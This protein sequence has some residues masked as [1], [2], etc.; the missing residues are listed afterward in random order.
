MA[1]VT[2]LKNEG[3][4]YFDLFDQESQD[5]ENLQKKLEK[6]KKNESHYLYLYEHY[7]RKCESLENELHELRKAAI[8]DTTMDTVVSDEIVS[9][10]GIN[11]LID[12]LSR[13]NIRPPEPSTTPPLTLYSESTTLGS[14]FY[15]KR[16]S[17]FARLINNWIIKINT[18]SS[19][20]T[21]TSDP[22][23]GPPTTTSSDPSQ[24]SPIALLQ[25]PSQ[26]P[27]TMTSS[28]PLQEPSIAASSDPLQ[29][30]PIAISR[31]PSSYQKST[32]QEPPRPPPL[33]QK[34]LLQG[35]YRPP[36]SYQKSTSQEPPRPPPLYQKPLLQGPYRPPPSYQ[37]STSQEPPRP[38]PLYQKP[39][40]QGPYR[41]PLQGP[42][43]LP[44]SYQKLPS[45][46]PLIV[47]SLTTTSSL[48]ASSSIKLRKRKGEHSEGAAFKKS[49]TEGDIFFENEADNLNLEEFLGQSHDNSLNPAQIFKY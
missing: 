28:D 15:P 33:Y 13:D 5:T 19:T 34:P 9:D 42:S 27:S 49:H 23:Q 6:H 31:L 47:T 40:L 22:P 35:P 16:D 29:G 11:E 32:S 24:G 44:S 14:I 41:P 18:F 2:Y 48:S 38:P 12:E 39:L 46:E 17:E 26:E 25:D 36:P 4:L 3:R 8:G 30:P 20:P 10:D 37:K 7:K 21:T 1:T 45:Q 43:Q